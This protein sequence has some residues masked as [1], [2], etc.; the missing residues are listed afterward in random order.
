MDQ[1]LDR[2]LSTVN[3]LLGNVKGQG[4]FDDTIT[5]L[6]TPKPTTGLIAANMPSLGGHNPLSVSQEVSNQAVAIKTLIGELSAETMSGMKNIRN[7]NE[8]KSVVSSLTGALD[9]ANS[10]EKIRT[11]LEAVQKQLLRARA[12]ATASA[13]HPLSS[14]LGDALGSDKDVFLNP[15]N[16]YYNGATVVKEPSQ[17]T[18]TRIKT[19]NPK[20]GEIE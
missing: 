3:Q 17:D 16:P 14:D 5:A 20:T 18:G 12:I 1:K 2:G 7:I 11:A 4:T 8:F 9:A 19:Y 10:P 15:N 6:K 13:G